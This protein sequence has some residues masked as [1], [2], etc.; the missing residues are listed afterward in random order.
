MA[1]RSSP[2]A[3]PA[4]P[5]LRLAEAALARL[6][7]AR[8]PPLLPSPTD[9]PEFWVQESGVPR[10]AF[11][12]FVESGEAPTGTP[13]PVR[14]VADA[15]RRASAPPRAIAVVPSDTAARAVWEG[16]RAGPAGPIDAELAVL[17]VPESSG[18]AAHWHRG[19][20]PPRTLLRL[21]TGVAVGLFR[22]AQSSEGSSQVDFS[23]MLEIL[24]SRFQVD[25]AG[26]LGVRTDE[27]ALF[28]LYQLAQRHSYA[29]GDA[30]SE[31]YTVALRPFGPG[32][33]VPWYAA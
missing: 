30:G 23:E 16:G 20:L 1:A 6:G 26:S 31:L 2:P 8:I 11:P 10:R 9:A 15:A 18:G 4:P 32:P 7:F 24:K 12:V 19:R 27:E 22:Q 14:W 13:R 3:P 5:S 33:R 29:P 17:V 25:V 21:A 28:M